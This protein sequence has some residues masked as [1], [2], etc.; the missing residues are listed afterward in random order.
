M[1]NTTI[2]LSS[3]I[4]GLSSNKRLE[5]SIKLINESCA[6]ILLFSGHT[7]G[8]VNDI[9]TLKNSITNKTILVI[10]ELENINSS[11]INNCLYKIENGILTSLYTNQL[12]TQSSEIEDNYELADRMLNEFET[13][14]NLNINGYKVLI[15][16]CGELNIIKNFQS[17]NNNVDF[18]L[19]DNKTLKSKFL[20][21]IKESKI[22]LNPIHTPMGNQGKLN[23]RRVYLSK[24]KKYYFSVSN[25]KKQSENLRLKSIQYAF[26]NGRPMS[27]SDEKS[28]PNSISR[29]FE[30]Q[31]NN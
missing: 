20:R 28:T 11:K 22:I 8:F 16:Q 10:L 27:C 14:R 12:F 29:V 21:I 31:N 13:K 26:Y 4:S 9:E 25:S 23:K 7:I 2:E 19:S 3:F 18:R 17:D 6:D 30:I 24:N 5:L 1:K 15:I